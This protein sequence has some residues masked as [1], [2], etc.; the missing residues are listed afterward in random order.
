M[1]AETDRW[2]Q[3]ALGGELKIPVGSETL[4]EGAA[5]ELELVPPQLGLNLPEGIQEGEVSSAQIRLKF[6]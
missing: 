4:G 6:D 3:G 2:V 5:L 1:S